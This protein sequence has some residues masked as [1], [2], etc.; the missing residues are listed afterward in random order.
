MT[1]KTMSRAFCKCIKR[2]K[3]TVKP[4]AG[5][6]AEGA[7]IAICT[8]TLLFPKGRTLKRIRCGPKNRLTTQKRARTHTGRQD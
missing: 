4:R 3:Q 2:V 7:A 6:T 5:T 8:K 1:R